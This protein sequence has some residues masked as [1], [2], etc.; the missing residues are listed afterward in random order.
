MSEHEQGMG[1]AV[2]TCRH[3]QECARCGL[4]QH[5]TTHAE[6][7]QHTVEEIML[8]SDGAKQ[9]EA[10]RD[11]YRE[12]LQEIASD[13]ARPGEPA[14]QRAMEALGL[15]VEAAIRAWHD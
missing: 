7:L 4:E 5:V 13:I 6:Q 1:H 11:R 14:W 2:S 8:Y 12:A 9:V 10:E 15:D 3:K